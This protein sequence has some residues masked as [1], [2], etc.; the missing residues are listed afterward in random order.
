MVHRNEKKIY[1]HLHKHRITKKYSTCTLHCNNNY[2]DVVQIH[3]TE[4]IFPPQ[5]QRLI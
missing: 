4:K 1:P 5:Q 3:D 2:V